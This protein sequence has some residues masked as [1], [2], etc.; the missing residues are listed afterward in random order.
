ML[1][2]R[3]FGS[4]RRRPSECHVRVRVVRSAVDD[5]F[6]VSRDLKMF[7]FNFPGFDRSAANK[8]TPC[9]T[10]GRVRCLTRI[11]DVSYRS[12]RKTSRR[13]A[14]A[15]YHVPSVRPLRYDNDKTLLTAV[16]EN[17]RS[18]ERRKEIFYTKINK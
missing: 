11:N 13:S 7:P 1:K 6:D 18:E 2:H 4:I 3:W 5:A 16:A 8:Q 17:R 14:T 10:I 15:H 12:V 9:F